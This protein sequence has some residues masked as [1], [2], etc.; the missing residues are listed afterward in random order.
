[1]GPVYVPRRTMSMK[2]VRDGAEK[3]MATPRDRV[4]I[5]CGALYWRKLEPSLELEPFELPGFVCGL[6]RDTLVAA[7]SGGTSAKLPQERR[8]VEPLRG[9]EPR[10]YALQVRRSTP[11]LKRPAASLPS[12][13]NPRKLLNGKLKYAR[14]KLP[15]LWMIAPHHFGRWHEKFC[16]SIISIDTMF[17][18]VRGGT[19]GHQ[20][21]A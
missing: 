13:K 19:S 7:K 10:T 9:I 4:A 12:F 1:M 21:N 20:W 14:I 3:R 18:M 15:A 16:R 2:V 11:E 17:K 8:R 5:V 6:C